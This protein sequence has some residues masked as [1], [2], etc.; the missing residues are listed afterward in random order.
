MEC[1]FTTKFRTKIKNSSS[2]NRKITISS[3][4]LMFLRV[5]SYLWRVLCIRLCPR[6]K[7]MESSVCAMPKRCQ[8]HG[9]GKKVLE[10]SNSEKQRR[11]SRS[12]SAKLECE[13]R[14]VEARK[15]TRQIEDG[16]RQRVCGLSAHCWRYVPFERYRSIIII[17]LGISHRNAKFVG[18]VVC[19]QLARATITKKERSSDR[20]TRSVKNC[21]SV[22]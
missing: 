18:V 3:E 16:E 20:D 6:E 14:A 15:K 8:T 19:V 5:A 9:D 13:M 11:P 2:V 1:A 12:R 17:S 10:Y 7:T 22:I 21:D 4:H